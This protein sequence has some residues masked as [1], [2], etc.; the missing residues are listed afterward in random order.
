MKEYRSRGSDRHLS[1]FLSYADSPQ[2]SSAHAAKDLNIATPYRTIE[3]IVQILV[4]EA[5]LGNGESD[6]AH[7]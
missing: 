2:V 4:I 5:V 1:A 7:A 3:P 6:Y